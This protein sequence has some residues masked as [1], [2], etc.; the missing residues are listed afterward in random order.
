MNSGFDISIVDW[1]GSTIPDALERETLGS[2][3]IRGGPNGRPLIEVEDTIART[4]RSHI[5]VPAY[6][7]AQSSVRSR[8]SSCAPGT[9]LRPLRPIA[10]ST[11]KV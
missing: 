9:N 5:N 7:L 3:A 6:M 11:T 10:A 2:L 4:V 8:E 1:L